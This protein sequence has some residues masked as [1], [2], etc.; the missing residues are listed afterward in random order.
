MLQGS[1]Q[2]CKCQDKKSPLCDKIM[3]HQGY[4]GT[5]AAMSK[6]PI[7]F[8]LLCIHSFFHSPSSAFT[9]W[10]HNSFTMGR[11]LLKGK[12][13]SKRPTTWRDNNSQKTYHFRQTMV[14]LSNDDDK[15]ENILDRTFFNP[16]SIEENSPLR[17]FANL[18]QNDYE[19]AE[20]LYVGIILAVLVLFSQ[21]LLRYYINGDQYIPFH[22]GGSKF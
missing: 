18:V 5:T 21:E 2:Q 8:F 11:Q 1:G 15:D 7:C 13:L 9:V 22:S 16:S 6:F 12:T 17:W 4:F 19:T 3:H 10:T 14:L 20:G